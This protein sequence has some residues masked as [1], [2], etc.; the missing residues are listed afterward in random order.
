M[1]SSVILFVKSLSSFVRP[2]VL[3]DVNSGNMSLPDIGHIMRSRKK[4]AALR[5]KFAC[6]HGANMGE[7]K[8][9][10]SSDVKSSDGLSIRDR[11]EM[12]ISHWFSPERPGS[13]DVLN[14][15]LLN[16]ERNRIYALPR[17]EPLPSVED[18]FLAW[19]SEDE[20]LFETPVVELW[21]DFEGERT[22][23]AIYMESGP[24]QFDASPSQTEFSATS[25][26]AFWID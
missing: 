20:Y 9:R 23:V 11:Q 13:Q 8:R 12:A 10:V 21:R 3:A 22:A 16:F 24:S 19:S 1:I 2:E 6:D 15:R 18:S 5:G 25:S 7:L 14:E 26:D 17:I 4:M